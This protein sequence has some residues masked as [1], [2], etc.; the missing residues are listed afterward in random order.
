LDSSIA[1]RRAQENDDVALS[2]SPGLASAP[3]LGLSTLNVAAAAP[4]AQIRQAMTARARRRGP[5][6]RPTRS[7]TNTQR[8]TRSRSS[9]AR[10]SPYFDMDDEN[11]RDGHAN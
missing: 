5:A 8:R 10:I 4:L 7:T 11:R 9:S 3:Q 1:A 6:A 2:P